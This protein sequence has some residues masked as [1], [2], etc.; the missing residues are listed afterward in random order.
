MQCQR[1]V[2]EERN[3]LFMQISFHCMQAIVK[4]AK[5]QNKTHSHFLIKVTTEKHDVN[6]CQY[7]LEVEMYRVPSSLR[8][9]IRG[10]EK[11]M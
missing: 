4:S 11:D 2:E 5:K 1:C 9:N 8:H 3:H 6:H 10:R 7:Q